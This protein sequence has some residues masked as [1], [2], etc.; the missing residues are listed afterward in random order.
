MANTR[1]T[2][3]EEMSSL[4]QKMDVI[5]KKISEL[6]TT[7]HEMNNFFL[8]TLKDDLMVEINDM[9]AVLNS[10]TAN[11]STMLST[12]FKNGI[13]DSEWR[14][15]I[16]QR[17]FAYYEALRNNSIAE[18][19]SNALDNPEIPKIPKKFFKNPTPNLSTME[20]DL[21]KSLMKK[22]VEHEIERLKMTAALKKDFMDKI[23]HDMSTQIRQNYDPDEA[24]QQFLK[25][26]ECTEKEAKISKLIWEKK[27]NFFSSD[28][29]LLPIDGPPKPIRRNQFL[30]QGYRP[31]FVNRPNW[32]NTRPFQTNR[33]YGM[34]NNFQ[35]N[36]Q[37]QPYRPFVRNFRPNYNRNFRYT[38]FRNRNLGLPNYIN[39]NR[40]NP[41]DVTAQGSTNMDTDAANDHFLD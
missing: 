29:H 28:F 5:L 38:N 11:I 9:K 8:N 21:Q 14:K 4:H 24:S 3:K 26:S 40:S 41:L 20:R 1:N 6:N 15:K 36:F 37:N 35:N 13:S 27:A 12:N 25:W 34:R 19:Y 17:K 2:A 10:Q 18:I 33:P 30:N 31:N 39:F 22:E 23:D 7:I 32:T 16:T